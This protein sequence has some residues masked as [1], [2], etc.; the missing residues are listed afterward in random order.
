MAIQNIIFDMGNVLVHD[1]MLGYIA[2]SI[3]DEIDQKLIYQEL[4]SGPEWQQWD[5]GTMNVE[6]ASQQVEKRL[7]KRLVGVCAALMNGWHRQLNAVEGVEE[8]ITMLKEKGYSIFLLS[9]TAKTYYEYCHLLPAIEQFDGEFISADYQL[10][11]PSPEIYNAFVRKFNLKP[12]EC[13]F[14][15][16][17]QENIEGAKAAGWSGFCFKK[18]IADLTQ[19]LKQAGVVLGDERD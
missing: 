8:L 17:V 18:N 2:K 7:P 9:N 13:F 11:K 19:S 6:Q 12:E 1:D 14:V 5:C 4:M 3:E 10:L 15:D 16:D